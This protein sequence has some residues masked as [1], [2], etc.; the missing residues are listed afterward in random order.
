MRSWLDRDTLKSWQHR[1]WI[2]ITGPDFR[3]KAQRVLD[4]HPSTLPFGLTGS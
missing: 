2:F 4:L 3:T 1:C